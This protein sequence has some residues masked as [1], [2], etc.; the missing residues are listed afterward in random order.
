MLEGCTPRTGSDGK[1]LLPPG[2]S[3]QIL[4]SSV[5]T[6]VPVASVC[7]N[8]CPACMWGMVQLSPGLEFS[9]LQMVFAFYWFLPMAESSHA[10][11]RNCYCLVRGHF[12]RALEKE[13]VPENRGERN[14]DV[15][16]WLMGWHGH[17]WPQRPAWGWGLQEEFWKQVAKTCFYLRRDAMRVLISAL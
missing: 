7:Q 1:L 3:W 13:P 4:N 5:S 16:F 9:R 11:R 14:Q 12:Q 2:G 17:M 15:I 6:T 8:P 10:A